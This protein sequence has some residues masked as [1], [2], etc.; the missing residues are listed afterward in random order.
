MTIVRFWVVKNLPLSI[1]FVAC[2]SDNLGEF[3]SS[4]NRAGSVNVLSGVVDYT[5][6]GSV[7]MLICNPGYR[8]LS[9][10]N[11]TCGSDG[12]WSEEE[13]S[14]VEADHSGSVCVCTIE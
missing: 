7:A 9:S 10:I 3:P 13:L 4:L 5:V 8:P 1:S 14:C 2:D 12:H 11:R 6:S